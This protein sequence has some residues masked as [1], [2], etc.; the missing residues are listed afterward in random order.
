M[1][2]KFPLNGGRPV[3]T[4]DPTGR[5]PN[6]K[7]TNIKVE[8]HL[9]IEHDAEVP[10]PLVQVALA[11]A[12]EGSETIRIVATNFTES[13]E[14]A[15]AVAVLLQHSAM[16]ILEE[17]GKTGEERAPKRPRFNPQPV[18]GKR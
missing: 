8:V 18:G 16:A 9:E 13:V 14:G 7:E 5:V 2:G 15:E 1:A 3:S 12:D 17:I 10:F 6:S 4:E 11:D